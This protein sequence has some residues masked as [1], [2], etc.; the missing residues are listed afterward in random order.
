MDFITKI[1]DTNGF[2]PRWNC[3][4]AWADDPFIGWL[5]IVSDTV[6]W[7]AYL[8]MLCV[9]VFFLLKRKEVVFPGIFWL[10]GVFIFSCGTVHLL[11]VIIFWVPM[12]RLSGVLKCVAALSSALTVIA[13]VRIAPVAVSFP[14]LAESNARLQ[15]QI[16]ERENAEREL[17]EINADLKKFSDTVVD[18]ED[19]MIALKGEVNHLLSEIGRPPRYEL[20]L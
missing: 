16:V 12:Y 8:L 13:L 10:F 9:L 2:L 6:T 18:R 19:R 1:F 4:A 14:G 7:V 20:G 11:E 17:R 3:G 15:Q 5:H